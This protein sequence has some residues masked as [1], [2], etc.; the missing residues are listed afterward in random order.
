MAIWNKKN[1]ENAPE[2]PVNNAAAPENAG[3][4]GEEKEFSYLKYLEREKVS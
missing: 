2:E 1:N 3:N 4:A